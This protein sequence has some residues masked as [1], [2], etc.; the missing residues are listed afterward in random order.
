MT[1]RDAAWRLTLS[2]G[3]AIAAGC[4]EQSNTPSTEKASAPAVATKTSAEPDGGKLDPEAV[5]TVVREFLTAIQQG[6]PEKAQSRLTPLTRE[7]TK[8]M[9][10]DVAPPGSATAKFEIGEVEFKGNTGA[11]VA[12]KWIDDNGAG[13]KRT[14][15]VVWMVRRVEEG[16][17]ICG[18]G[19]KVFEDQPPLFLNFEDPQEMARKQKAVEAE[20]LRRAKAAQTPPS[21]LR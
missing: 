5:R 17:R 4:G 11:Y 21:S 18:L 19:A 3:L 13:Q 16:W 15:D 2:W 6:N 14:D 12:T 1:L 9:G 20:H 10:I 7:K 8:E